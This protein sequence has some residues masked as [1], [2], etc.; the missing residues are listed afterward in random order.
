MQDLRLDLEGLPSSPWNQEVIRLLM[1]A[2]KAMGEDEGNLPDEIAEELISNKLLHLR[3][4]WNTANSRIKLDGQEETQE[5]IHTRLDKTRVEMDKT[6]R[7]HRRRVRVSRYPSSMTRCSSISQR[8]ERR[9]KVIDRKVEKKKA[10]LE[11][12]DD[13]EVWEW[14]KSLMK[15]L[16]EEGMSSDESETEDHRQVFVAKSMPWRRDCREHMD[17]MDRERL[18]GD[19]F[20]KR[21][22]RPDYRVRRADCLASSRKIPE[23]LP[24]A[25]Y[26]PQWVDSLD[27]RRKHSVYKP[28]EAELEWK[29]ITR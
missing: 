11:L 14:L 28:G 10:G 16:G 5:E 1:V 22:H 23:G 3:R 7:R 29:V 15:A 9:C 24:K 17:I 21:G 20:E 13:L 19:L 18:E 25:V 26:S 6:K 27:Q 8:Y 4:V 12:S 2:F